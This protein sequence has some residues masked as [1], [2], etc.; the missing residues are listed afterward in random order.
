MYFRYWFV[1]VGFLYIFTER[2]F[3]HNFVGLRCRG[4]YG[5]VQ[6]F[7]S[8]LVNCV[9]ECKVLMWSSSFCR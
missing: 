3:C 7:S 8:S 2:R 1:C 9:W 5:R 6:L 4:I